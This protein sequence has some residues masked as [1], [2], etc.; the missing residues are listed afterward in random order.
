MEYFAVVPACP[1]ARR[2][3]WDHYLPENAGLPNT[4]AGASGQQ[5]AD[6]QLFPAGR[7]LISVVGFLAPHPERCVAFSIFPRPISQLCT[8][9]F[10]PSKWPDS[11]STAIP[12]VPMETGTFPS[13]PNL[14]CFP[15]TCVQ[16]L[17]P[18]FNQKIINNN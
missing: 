15:C 5:V 6:N 1:V 17:F 8:D 9:C 3:C 12:Y 7:T 10:S 18:P 16:M 2:Q 11:V 4:T 14:S 13:Q